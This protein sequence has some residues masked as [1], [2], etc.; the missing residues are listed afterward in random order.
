MSG[1]ARVRAW[2]LSV[3]RRLYEEL[4]AT[5]IATLVVGVLAAGVVL[6]GAGYVPLIDLHVALVERPTA[7]W[8]ALGKNGYLLDSPGLILV[9][10]ALGIESRLAFA[11]LAFVVI[12]AGLGWLVWLAKR[13]QGDVE[14]RLVAISFFVA[15]IGAVLIT[16]LGQPD[17]ITMTAAGTFV[18]ARGSLVFP[19]AGVV[20]GFNHFE[21]GVPI[22]LASAALTIA[23]GPARRRALDALL[24]AAGLIAGKLVLS[25]WQAMNGQD[26]ISRLDY[27]LQIGVHRWLVS[28]LSN[29]PAL[30][31]STF[32]L[33]WPLMAVAFME[34]WQSRRKV[35]W[36]MLAATLLAAAVTVLALDT[37]RVFA[38]VSWPLVLF[39]VTR[40]P[41][42]RLA[43][44][45]LMAGIVIPRF[46]VW[47]G[48]VF[49]SGF[50]RLLVAAFS[51][52]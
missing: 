6:H 16:W 3:H 15:P 31:F 17:P 27:L 39:A 10:H 2:L 29:V 37:T 9:G 40:A 44:W 24:A 34:H 7:A 43:V 21:A 50:H 46:I 36:A 5:R 48:G 28:V 26:P 13:H 22:V 47:D 1:T 12:A 30:L 49:S 11:S 32:S 35:A 51:S 38:L 41:D 19:V 14:A 25:W 42:V 52:R 4:L 33:A 45:C 18:L 8:E 20:L 23:E